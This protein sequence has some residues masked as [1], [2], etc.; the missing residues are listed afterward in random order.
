MHRW[1]SAGAYQFDGRFAID[2]SKV[3]L[4]LFAALPGWQVLFAD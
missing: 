1:V 3:V 4:N 2:P